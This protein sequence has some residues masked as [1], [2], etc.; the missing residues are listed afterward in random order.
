MNYKAISVTEFNRLLDQGEEIKYLRIAEKV[1][2]RIRG[3]KTT[4]L[5]N[6]IFEDS[7]IL[8][9]IDF[10]GDLEFENCEFKSEV[11]FKE[12]KFWEKLVLKNCFA[13]KSINFINSS[14]NIFEIDNFDCDQLIFKG[15]VLSIENEDG[16]IHFIGG[17]Y[18]SISFSPKEINCSIKL[19]SSKI[20]DLSFTRANVNKSI[21]FDSSLEIDNLFIESTNFYGRWDLYDCSIWEFTY[22]HKSNFYEQVVFRKESH[23]P[24]LTLASVYAKQ[25]FS[26]DYLSNID[27]LDISD[28]RFESNF[29][30]YCY[31]EN[32]DYGSNGIMCNIFGVFHGNAVFE[33]VPITNLSIGAVNFGNLTFNRIRTKLI[34][35]QNFHNYNKLTIS[36]TILDKNYNLLLIYNSNINDTEFIDVNFKKFNEVV[37]AKS[38]VSNIVLSNSSFP[39]S[40]QI[41][42][43][44]P[45]L[46]YKFERHESINKNMYFRETYRQLKLAMERQDNRYLSLQFKAK[47][48]HYLRKE[49]KIGWDKTLL[50]LNF[51]SNNHGISWIRGIVFT[52]AVSFIFFCI[53]NS[54]LSEQYFYWDISST[55]DQTI[56]AFVI[57]L[58]HFSNFI[59]SFPKL[60][61]DDNSNTWQTNLSVLVSRILIGYG[62]YQTITAYRKYGGK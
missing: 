8:T 5:S 3:F 32:I 33:N 20:K 46:G 54:T 6:C 26:V 42:A 16:E 23:I 30:L 38:N 47:E 2:I 39:H 13:S 41:E 11:Y 4:R 55:M 59:A 14:F 34:F 10:S 15:N 57:G 62:I 53:Y 56:E 25:N 61:L 9:N 18:K 29:N 35:L 60:R 12:V 27:T 31:E 22:L 43:K 7:I 44:S 58:N 51:V 1:E 21:S 17:S 45:I 36:N 40:I 19:S 49:L 24:S 28:C 50:Y 48:M 37:I 52:I